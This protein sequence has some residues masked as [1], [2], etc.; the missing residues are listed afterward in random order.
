MIQVINFTINKQRNEKKQ[1]NKVPK[2]LHAKSCY[3]N[4]TIVK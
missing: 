4:S 3:S 2:I 1:I